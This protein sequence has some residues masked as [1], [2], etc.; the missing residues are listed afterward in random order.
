[1]TIDEMY[2]ST[3]S[4]QAPLIITQ[5][6]DGRW[7]ATHSDWYGYDLTPGKALEQ[8]LRTYEADV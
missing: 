5:M 7:Y 3:G 1:M 2:A 6:E 4:P 8:L